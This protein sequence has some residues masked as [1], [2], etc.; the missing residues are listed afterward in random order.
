MREIVTTVCKEIQVDWW[1][2]GTRKCRAYTSSKMSCIL[3]VLVK[4]SEKRRLT[5]DFVE[6]KYQSIC[7][8]HNTNKFQ[9]LA[10]SARFVEFPP[11]TWFLIGMVFF[12][13]V[14]WLNQRS[15]HMVVLCW[16]KFLGREPMLAGLHNFWTEKENC[17]QLERW[18][19]MLKDTRQWKTSKIS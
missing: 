19:Q 6:N 3:T 7:E 1:Q 15:T 9:S 10:N 4:T 13:S 16:G 12:W 2:S 5:V 18:K 14:Q 17:V 11:K 8:R